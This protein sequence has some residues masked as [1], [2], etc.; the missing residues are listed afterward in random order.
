MKKL[1]LF[2]YLLS[3][4]AIY[5]YSQNISLSNSHGTIVSGSMIDQVG[6]PDS[7]ELLTYLY[8]KNTGSKPISVLCKKYHLSLLDSTEVL[9]CWAGSCY[10]PET[11]V[12]PNEQLIT[13]GQT[14]KDFVGHYAST[15]ASFLLN[16]GESLIRWV[17]YDSAS[18][19]DSASVTVKYTTYPLGI[20]DSKGNKGMLSNMYPNPASGNASCSYTLPSGARGAIVIRDILGSTLQTQVLPNDSGRFT[21]NTMNLSDGVYFCSLL[22]E[23]KVSQTKKLIV[24]H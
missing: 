9:M 8:V 24:K 5:G 16:P 18:P 2:I 19:N 3:I 4:V 11:Y 12:S 1:I 20:E 15:K 13:S 10:G 7:S 21:V 6:T 23:G 14:I 17:F 22:V